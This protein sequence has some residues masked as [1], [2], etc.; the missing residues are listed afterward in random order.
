MSTIEAEQTRRRIHK[1]RGW[2]EWM[3]VVAMDRRVGGII[4]FA[5]TPQ[6]LIRQA[7]LLKGGSE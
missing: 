4:T 6:F 7:V 3:V 5:N 1:Q 2:C